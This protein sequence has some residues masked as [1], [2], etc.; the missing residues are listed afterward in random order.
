MLSVRQVEAQRQPCALTHTHPHTLVFP[1]ALL[2]F[3]C[4]GDTAGAGQEA[5]GVAVLSKMQ[6]AAGLAKNNII[7]AT[8][9]LV[10]ELKGDAPQGRNTF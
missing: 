5:C 6:Q 7:R 2:C 1:Q 9:E 4:N 3:L 10:K 8:K